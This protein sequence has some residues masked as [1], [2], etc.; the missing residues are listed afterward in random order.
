LTF[1]LDDAQKLVNQGDLMGARQLLVKMCLNHPNDPLLNYRCACVHDSLGME[2]DAR[3]YYE[4]AIRLG[5]Q[6]ECLEGAFIGLG[7][8]YR[9]LGE[10]AKSI[11]VLLEGSRQFPNSR[12]MKVFEA[13]ALHESGKHNLAVALLLHCIAER[14]GDQSIALYSRAI[15]EY[16]QAYGSLSTL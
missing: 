16:A 3:P 14:P 6:G 13:M 5:L 12:V 15:Q 1:E 8:T 2:E 9:L 7:S 4:N 11:E 10:H